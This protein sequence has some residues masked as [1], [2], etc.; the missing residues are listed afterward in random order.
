MDDPDLI[1][2]CTAPCPAV[3]PGHFCNLPP[4]AYMRSF[5]ALRYVRHVLFLLNFC[6]CMVDVIPHITTSNNCSSSSSCGLL[7]ISSSA[8]CDR[9]SSFVS[10]HSGKATAE[11][12]G[13]FPQY[14]Q[15]GAR[16]IVCSAIA[17][18]VCFAMPHVIPSQY[19]LW[20]RCAESDLAIR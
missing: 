15:T 9:P 8:C 14:T 16:L 11:R 7:S 17:G 13:G 5:D 1:C 10:P 6:V 12:W 20:H 2:N 19:W 18:F 4:V 3:Q